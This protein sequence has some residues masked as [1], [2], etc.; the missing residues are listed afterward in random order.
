MTGLS[1]LLLFS[2]ASCLALGGLVMWRDPRNATNRAFAVLAA[3]LMLWSLGVFLIIHAVDEAQARFF[4]RATFVVVSFLPAGLYLFIAL[5]PR[6]R[7][8]G[9]RALLALLYVFGGLSIAGAFTPQWY[10]QRITVLE[11]AP[12]LVAYG[13]VF[14]IFSLGI[15]LSTICSFVNMLRKLRTAVGIERS[16]VQYVILGTFVS[17]GLAISSNVFAP[18]LGIGSTQPFGP[19]FMVVMAAFFAYAMIRYHLMSISVII[20]RTG[21]YA[22]IMGFVIVVFLGTVA[23]VHLLFSGGGYT[24]DLLPTVLAALVIALGLQPLK[25]RVQLVLERTLL[26]RRYDIHR[27][28]A[29]TGQHASQAANF[30]ERLGTI[31]LDIRNTIGVASIRVLL[32]DEANPDVLVVEYTDNPDERGARV[33]GYAEFLGVLRERPAPV[34]LEQLQRRAP[35]LDLARLIEPMKSLGAALCLPLKSARDLAGIM[36]LGEKTS[37]DPFRSDDLMVF[38]A[39][40]GPLATAIENARLYRQLEEANQHRARILSHMRGGVIAVDLD[41]RVTTANHYATELLGAIAVGTHV[42]GLPAQVG[43]ILEATLTRQSAVR[44]LETLIPGADGADVPVMLSSSVLTS[45]G[46]AP[47]GAMITIYDLTQVKRLEQNVQRVHRLSS[48]GTLAA[49]MA[50]EIKNPLVSIK[51]FTQ[52]L[53]NRYDD[54]DFR[55]TFTDIVPHEVERIDSIVSRLLDFARP[56]PIRFAPHDVKKVISEVLTL[57]ENQ[58]QKACI[59]IETRFPDDPLEIYGDEQQIHQVFLNLVLN[60]IDA[61]TEVEGGHLLVSAEFGT[62]LLRRSTLMPTLEVDCI[63]IRIVDTGCGIPQESLERI[64]T[65]FFSTKESGTGLGLSIVHG[66][67]TE[68]GGEI[69]V[70]SSRK[71]GTCFTVTLPLARTLASRGGG[72]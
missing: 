48:I 3:N 58:A 12:P 62:M 4:L 9:S 20:S 54:P 63:R 51:T 40:S 33:E 6:Q 23:V 24:E 22:I 56:K 2:A 18:I 19:V 60:A 1:I 26:K 43:S 59:T 45:A 69:D 66:I 53:L 15:V 27:L 46:G 39:L 44:D 65:P 72:Q 11:D 28:L 7:F 71:E 49:G 36:L 29:R 47:A 16:Q 67:V 31:C 52:L 17:T 35:H 37:R 32:V 38:T 8:E 57:V 70:A 25:E 10:I 50:H 30:E 68:H 42:S 5:F 14:Y 21:V 64:F 61:M 13:P 34:V 55:A 41:G